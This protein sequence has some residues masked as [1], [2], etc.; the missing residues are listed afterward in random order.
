[1]HIPLPSHSCYTSCPSTI[2]DLII[3]IIL[4]EHYKLWSSSLCSF[5]QPP[6]TSS[7]FDPNILNTLFSNTLSQCPSLN[8]RDQASQPYRTAG[9][10]IVLYILL[11]MFLG[12]RRDDER[13]CTGW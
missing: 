10:I 5:L 4:S 8:D 2:L 1:L 3:L 6:V 12:S 13:I 11:L 9:K 7:P